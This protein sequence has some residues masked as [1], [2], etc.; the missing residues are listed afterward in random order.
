MVRETLSYSA[1]LRLPTTMTKQE[2]NEVV[3]DTIIKM[4]LHADN[5]IGNWHLSGI[6][7]GEKRRLSISVEILAQGQYKN[8]MIGLEFD[9]PVPR[10]AKWE[11]E[12]ILRDYF[13]ISTDSSKWWDL[14]ALFCLLFA[15][16][17]LLFISLRYKKKTSSLIH[18]LFTRKPSLH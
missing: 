18:R 7:G 1:H 8:D 4:G 5:K 11:G 10:Q 15:S 6:S 3:E 9:P 13:G 14:G 12:T 2:I 16:R 17:L